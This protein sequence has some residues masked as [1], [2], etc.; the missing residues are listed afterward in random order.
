[1]SAA[2]QFAIRSARP[3]QGRERDLVSELIAN[4]AV[5]ALVHELATWPKP[6]L[7]SHV[8]SGSHT[9]MDA[10]MMQASAESLRPFFGEFAAA[11]HFLGGG[12]AEH[13]LN[14]FGAGLGDGFDFRL[15]HGD[16]Q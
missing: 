3:A 11:G 5:L 6:G 12:G 15:G 14:V 8:D 13:L 1:M 2:P 4:Q 10:P 7:V 9:D 16:E